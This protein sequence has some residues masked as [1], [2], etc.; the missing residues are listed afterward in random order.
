MKGYRMRAVAAPLFKLAEAIM[1]LLVPLIV[2]SI[3]D[4]GIAG[5][6]RGYIVRRVILMIVFGIAGLIFAVT[7]QYFS[8]RVAVG[9]TGRV[10][11]ALFAHLGSLSYTE[12]DTIGTDTL[13]TRLTGD[14]NQIQNGVNLTLRLLLRSPFIVFGATVM[15]FTVDSHAALVFVALIPVL[16]LVIFAIML[17][18]V[19]LY[20]RVQERLDRVVSALRRN[21]AG[22]RVLRAFRKEAS[23]REDFANRT[24]ALADSQRTVGAIS[25]LLNPLT[26]CIVNLAILVLVYVGALRVDAGHLKQGE[27]V[28]LYNYMAQIL[29]ELVK[30]ANLIINITRAIACG[31]RVQSIFEIAPSVVSP[32]GAIPVPCRAQTGDA[33]HEVAAT[34]AG[35]AS[36]A[37]AQTAADADGT[38]TR[39]AEEAKDDAVILL[40]EPDK[41]DVAFSRSDTEDYLSF[42][43]AQMGGSD[44]GSSNA[45]ADRQ[46]TDSANEPAD[47]HGTDSANE[48]AEGQGTDSGDSSEGGSVRSAGTAAPIISFRDVSLRYA[49]AA[50]DMLSGI[51]CDIYRGE[52]VGV[53]GG[54]GSGKTSLV[55]LLPRFYDI[56]GG[57]LSVFG[58]EVREYDL[59]SLR[60]AIRIVPQK[61]VLFSGTVR[62]NLLW[63]RPD[64]T[65][66]ELWDA[67]DRACA[68]DFIR[69]LP[70]GLDAPVSKGGSNF[71]GGQRQR[72]TI[73]RAFVSDAE[74]LILDDSGSA[75]DYATE[76][77]LRKALRESGGKTIL[78]V[79]QRAGAL[80]SCDR[81]LVLEDGELVG[82]GRHEELLS[83][84]PVYR[85]I[86]AASGIDVGSAPAPDKGGGSK[87]ADG[88]DTDRNSATADGH[89]T[90]GNSAT[91]ADHDTVTASAEDE[92]GG[93]R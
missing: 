19:P 46:G 43:A 26:Y 55:Q 10:R 12:I 11:R 27:V 70:D 66:E 39:S 69:A 2:A 76:Q 41:G 37:D 81:I 61:A 71:S 83:T 52:Y 34:T 29:V 77:K 64:A 44:A 84:C 28:A 89:D 49:G 25:A 75:L 59:D 33:E 8:A 63:G 42:L 35:G 57:S 4:V 30:L 3:I 6:D 40:P 56:T 78:Y 90:G 51:N 17:I 45:P 1:E 86:A 9:Y 93:A 36:S 48:P 32:E 31:N 38:V 74:V 60:H 24:E 22:V 91:A 15:A 54:T 47:R 50:S 7:A 85:E 88:H 21:L 67:L 73:A 65:D 14:M 53:I 82:N 68:A 23:E 13:I 72:L 79:S 16:A 92:K 18:S 80:T 87:P 62:S 5:G 58:H 20:R